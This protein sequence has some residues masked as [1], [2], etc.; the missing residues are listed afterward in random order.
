MP[1]TTAI[2]QKQL[3]RRANFNLE[4]GFLLLRSFTGV[5]EPEF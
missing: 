3:L 1:S 5:N 4:A 2:G